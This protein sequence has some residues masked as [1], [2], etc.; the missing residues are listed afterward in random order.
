MRARL[1][2][3]IDEVNDVTVHIDPENDETNPS[4]AHLPLRHDLLSQL[5]PLWADTPLSQQIERITLHYL[6]GKVHLD[7]LVRLTEDADLDDVRAQER[8]LRAACA[9]LDMVGGVQISYRIAP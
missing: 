3:R 1:I 2:R 8:H 4:C 6:H 7:L 9:P 5:Q